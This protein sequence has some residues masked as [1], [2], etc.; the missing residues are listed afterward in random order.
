MPGNHKQKMLSAIAGRPTG[1]I[2]WAPR[3]D[4]WYRANKLAGTLPTKYRNASLGDIAEGLQA[5][6]HAIVPDFKGLREPAEEFDRSLGIYNLW[7]MPCRTVIENV[8]RTVRTEG[9]RTFV[10]YDTPAGKITT[11]TLYDESMRKAGITITHV[12]KHAF[13][14]PDDYK[15]IGFI[16]E[17]ARVEPNYSG[18]AEYAEQIGR[19]GLAAAFV[20]LAASPMHLIQREL[21]P[22]DVFFYE[23][24]DHA[25]EL[26]ELAEKIG[27]YWNRLLETVSDC[28]AELVFLGANYDASVT[29]P[30]FFAE[31]I[32]P[33]L[34]KFAEAMHARGKYLLTHTDG[35]NTGLL[36]HYVESQIDVADSIC[37]A[38]MTKLS[39]RQG[40]EFFDARVTI[41]GGIPSISLLASSMPDKEFDAFLDG[42]FEDIGGGDHLILGISD[43]TPPAADFARLE[44]I[45]RR[46]EQFGP[47]GPR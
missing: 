39:F 8:G 14:G 10:E 12:E 28:P 45:S 27:I 32:Q 46:V 35:E 7:C 21:M 15:A 23:M 17:N 37:P 29:Y 31:H 5:G 11:V 4:L 30:P 9:D 18:Y 13:T 16:F 2:P 6:M 22:L 25:D 24:Y 43:T 3:L 34:K 41:M 19:R 26:A 36:D 38:P 33:W 20:S 47:V 1:R 42:F 44:K 40:R